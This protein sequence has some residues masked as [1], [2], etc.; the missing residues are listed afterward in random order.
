MRPSEQT[1]ACERIRRFVIPEAAQR[2]RLT[3]SHVYGFLS[4]EHSVHLD[5]FGD[6]SRRLEPS[7]A[8]AHLLARGV[9]FE[10]EI[11]AGL[12]YA[13]PQFEAGD[14]EAGA[15][16]TR[17]LM[18]EGV[19][20]VYQGVLFDPPFLGIPD[21][22]RRVEVASDLGDWSY[23]V[24]DVKSSYKPRSDQALQV[25]FYSVL[26][27]GIQGKLPQE[28]YLI[29]RD[30]REERFSIPGLIPA[31]EELLEE[32]GELFSGECESHPHRS[33]AC[34]EC[35]WRSVCAEAPGVD[36]LPGLSRAE[37]SLLR[38]EGLTGLESLARLDPK[39]LARKGTMSEALLARARLHAEAV[40]QGRAVPRRRPRLKDRMGEG[41]PVLIWSDAFDRRY[42][43]FGVLPPGESAQ[44]F[45][46]ME[47]KDEAAAFD[48][49]RGALPE[50]Q[51][52]CHAGPFLASLHALLLAQ[53]MPIEGPS[54]ERRSLD[55]LNLAR[56]SHA[57][58]APVR[59]A[60]EVLG[61]LSGEEV[62]SREE[63]RLLAL[64][65][66]DEPTLRALAL[67]ELENLR[68][69]MQHLEEAGS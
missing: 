18:E 69:L 7:Q 46:A 21:L 64:E 51:S 27:E 66:R 49:W 50:G 44:V 2:D 29:L 35:R 53:G 9:A 33:F 11:V 20:G 43:V 17:V 59:E 65:D 32:I 68:Q 58:P 14:Y 1:A 3:G 8:L 23:E 67:E 24:G 40:I 22:M 41:C 6:K 30:G 12:D 42:L 37:R 48:A 19:S 61:W 28:G 15:R 47:P 45:V 4:C 52:L 60:S 34:R 31:L 38:F 54:L 25:A 63:E 57:F 26:L 62:P 13:E 5:F 39:A 56:G 10:D 16:G 36:W 55:L